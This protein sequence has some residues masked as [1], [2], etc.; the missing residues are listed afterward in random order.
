MK[1]Y[2]PLGFN[3]SVFKPDPGIMGG[4]YNP[5]SLAEKY[6]EVTDGNDVQILPLDPKIEAAIVD[7][8]ERLT[9]LGPEI[10]ITGFDGPG[11]TLKLHHVQEELVGFW[12]ER[13]AADP[14]RQMPAAPMNEKKVLPATD[15]ILKSEN[16]LNTQDKYALKDEDMAQVRLARQLYD[17]NNAI[18]VN[19]TRLV[20]GAT[21]QQDP[22]GQL[23]E[24]L[25]PAGQQEWQA[26]HRPQLDPDREAGGFHRPDR[27]QREAGTGHPAPEGAGAAR[28]RGGDPG[29]DEEEHRRRDAGAAD[30]RTRHAPC[31]GPRT[32]AEP[33]PPRGHAPVGGA[34][35]QAPQAPAQGEQARS[36]EDPEA[37]RIDRR[38]VAIG[39]DR[40]R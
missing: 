22:G 12:I 16:L 2:R 39:N 8:R 4:L 21:I 15:S 25:L 32:R 7:T 26:G 31:G 38:S 35:A 1:K 6:Q 40:R 9:A 20:R 3:A 5:V 10:V 37:R 19:F 23:P 13:C 30:R 34:G 14:D 33:G 27:R 11:I 24:R 29:A 17:D 36:S 28:D 18:V